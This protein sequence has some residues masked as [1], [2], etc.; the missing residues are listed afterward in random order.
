MSG[1]FSSY[2]RFISELQVDNQIIKFSDFG[3]KDKNSI[4]V[5]FG[6]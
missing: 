2:S 3:T 1:G 4:N 5:F 6:P